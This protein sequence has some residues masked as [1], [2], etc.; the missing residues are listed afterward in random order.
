[1][2]IFCSD[3]FFGVRSGQSQT[4]SQTE[5]MKYKKM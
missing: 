5:I 3:I 2:S 1:M 4:T